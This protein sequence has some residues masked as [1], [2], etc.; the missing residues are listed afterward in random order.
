M[1]VGTAL[2]QRALC[3][4]LQRKPQPLFTVQ[5]IFFLFS[6]FCSIVLLVLRYYVRVGVHKRICTSQ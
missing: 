5:T 3:W 2:V 4:P 6:L 1:S